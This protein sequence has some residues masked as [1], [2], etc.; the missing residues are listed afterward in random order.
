MVDRVPAGT[1]LAG[2]RLK[3]LEPVQT[4]RNGVYRE[5]VP[6][7]TVPRTSVNAQLLYYSVRV[8]CSPALTRHT[9]GTFLLHSDTKPSHSF[10]AT[11]MLS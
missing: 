9:L 5:H 4:T 7:G 6:T 11:C 10:T 3:D 1:V 8:N 2:T